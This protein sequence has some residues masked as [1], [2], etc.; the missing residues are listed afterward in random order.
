MSKIVGIVGGIG[1]LIGVYLFLSH[2]DSTAKIINTLASNSVSG[3]KTL[4]GR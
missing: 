3:I 2:G 4:Q 1:I